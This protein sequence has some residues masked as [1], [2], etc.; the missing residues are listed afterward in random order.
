M[1]SQAKLPTDS[2]SLKDI[3]GGEFVGK[4]ISEYGG[5]KIA[6]AE[7][8]RHRASASEIQDMQLGIAPAK[9]TPSKQ[10]V[11]PAAMAIPSKIPSVKDMTAKP[12]ETD[13]E[14]RKRSGITKIAYEDTG[15][16]P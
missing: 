2:Q 1:F 13:S 12:D 4:I 8:L 7:G 11:Q 15:H 10:N 3:P 5:D 14:C 6:N 9:A 16:D